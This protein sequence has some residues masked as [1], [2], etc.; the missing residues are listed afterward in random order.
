METSSNK[1]GLQLS[2]LARNRP[3]V[4]I[5]LCTRRST[6]SDTRT[7]I[8]CTSE[9]TSKRVESIW[10]QGECTLSAVS[11][12]EALTAAQLRRP[13]PLPYRPSSI[14]SPVPISLSSLLPCLPLPHLLLPHL[15]GTRRMLTMGE[16]IF[17]RHEISWRLIFKFL[18]YRLSF[19]F[20][21]YLI[22]ETLP[23]CWTRSWRQIPPKT[24]LTICSS[25][26]CRPCSSRRRKRFR[27]MQRSNPKL[28]RGTI[29]ISKRRPITMIGVLKLNVNFNAKV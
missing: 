18:F 25:R 2:A 7:G 4:S 6:R 29:W 20:S 23:Q 13:P 26:L 11:W 27:S 8:S 10:L 9:G 14:L 12:R 21:N 1:S 17:N 22:P 5:W 16:H 15:K 19:D 28:R 24:S 3:W